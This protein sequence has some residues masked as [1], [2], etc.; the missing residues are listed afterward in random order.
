MISPAI[1]EKF[2]SIFVKSNKLDDLS[3]VEMKYVYKIVLFSSVHK[4]CK[5]MTSL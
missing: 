3:K 2:Q 1:R 5:F 4:K